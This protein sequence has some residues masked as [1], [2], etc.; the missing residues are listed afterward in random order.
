MKVFVHQKFL[1][2]IN[3]GI[4]KIFLHPYYA[5]ESFHYDIGL[6]KLNQSYTSNTGRDYLASAICLP[7]RNFSIN[8]R[9]GLISGWGGGPDLHI[10]PVVMNE[11]KKDYE[12]DPIPFLQFRP[13]FQIKNCQV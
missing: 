10:S 11:Q 7:P 2:G 3:I 1:G 8:K 4:E 5:R 13:A 12:R 9:Y 6:I